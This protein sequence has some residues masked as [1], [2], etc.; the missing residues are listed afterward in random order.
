MTFLRQ[1]AATARP[2][3]PPEGRAGFSARD[4]NELFE[5]WQRDR[6]LSQARVI[7]WRER[8][9]VGT[10]MNHYPPDEQV[11]RGGRNTTPGVIDVLV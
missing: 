5:H 8:R 4:W 9:E 2:A 3:A 10:L 1:P 11:C 6:V 7:D